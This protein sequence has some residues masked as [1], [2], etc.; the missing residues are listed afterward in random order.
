[1]ARALLIATG[2]ALLLSLVVIMNAF[3]A[4]VV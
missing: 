1:M 3:A 2:V 4:P